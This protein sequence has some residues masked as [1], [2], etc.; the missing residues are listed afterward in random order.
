MS[1]L[2]SKPEYLKY[3]FSNSLGTLGSSIVFEKNF[4][5]NPI[6]YLAPQTDSAWGKSE[7]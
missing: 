6:F 4:L 2:T 5:I 1:S 3:K 7:S